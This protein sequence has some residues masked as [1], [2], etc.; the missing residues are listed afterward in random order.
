MWRPRLNRTT[1]NMSGKKHNSINRCIGL[2]LPQF[3]QTPNETRRR[4]NQRQIQQ[5]IFFQT[6]AAH[7]I[8][9]HNVVIANGKNNPE[10]QVGQSKVEVND[11]YDG[12]LTGLF[13]LGSQTP[14]VY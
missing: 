4:D 11:E 3:L 10:F 5:A 7:P 13:M 6:H 12:A 9:S 8:E 14:Y 2:T 1:I